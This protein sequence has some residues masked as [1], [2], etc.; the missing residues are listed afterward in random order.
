MAQ[1]KLSAEPYL[2]YYIGL[3]LCVILYAA[4]ISIY[5]SRIKKQALPRLKSVSLPGG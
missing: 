5:G 4:S 1:R 2:V 3:R